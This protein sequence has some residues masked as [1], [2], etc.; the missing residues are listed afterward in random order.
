MSQ[1]IANH[2]HRAFAAH[3]SG[4]V[5]KD[6]VKTPLEVPITATEV[7]KAAARL[8]NN[9]ASGPDDIPAELIKRLGDWQSDAYR[10]YIHIPV[11]DRML[12]VKR[13]ASFV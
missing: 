4:D 13:L 11:K 12:A 10:S 1:I 7:E 8:N 3:G 5:R 6:T 9:R 2:F